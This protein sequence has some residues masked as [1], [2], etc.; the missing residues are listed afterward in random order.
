M[1]SL[2]I[3]NQPDFVLGGLYVLAGLG[4]AL[5]ASSYEMGTL[6]Y[7][8]SGY[9]PFLLAILLCGIG[10]IIIGRS[11]GSRGPS[12]KLANWSPRS[13]FWM[14]GSIMIF[15]LALQPL[16]LI[17]ALVLLVV[18]AS[19]ASYEFT[20]KTTLVNA[21]VMVVVNVGGFAYGLSIPFPIFPDL[22]YF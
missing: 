3:K 5:A 21:F 19:L 20:W 14:V 4:F 10:L 2:S 13:L 1:S 18:L 6:S 15:G 8:G 12:L 22:I 16:G 17:V 9:F 7:M 11:I